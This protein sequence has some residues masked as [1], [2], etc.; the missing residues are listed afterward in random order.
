MKQISVLLS[1]FVLAIPGFQTHGQAFKKIPIERSGC[2]LY[3]YCDM[4]FDKSKSRDSSAIY[5][6]ECVQ[7]G[8][9]Y[10]V[11]CVKLE[12]PPETLPMAEDLLVA[13][14][15]FLKEKF[16]IIKAAGYGKG[17]LLNQDPG[18]RGVLDYWEDEEKNNWKVKAW[19]NRMYIGV[20][21]AY[22]SKNHPEQ[23]INLFLDGFRMP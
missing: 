9:T 21:Y 23:K 6:G 12:Y 4:K 5:A 1:F 17:L 16:G 22:S 2:S 13:Y 18:T 15:D 8:I 7:E 11:I 3:T 19:T 20:M 14:L 10:G